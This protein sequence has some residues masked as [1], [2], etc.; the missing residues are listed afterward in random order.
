[1]PQEI[2]TLSSKKR[3]RYGYYYV[4]YFRWINLASVLFVF[5]A[6][7][8]FLL[9]PQYEKARAESDTA[10]I[11]EELASLEEKLARLGKVKSTFDG[12]TLEDQEKID[13]MLPKQEN[14]ENIFPLIETLV[15]RNGLLLVS[16]KAEAVEE[17]VFA[18]KAEQL[19]EESGE[20]QGT[21]GSITAQKEEK[22]PPEIQVVKISLEITGVEYSG[23]KNLLKSLENN[24][25]LMDITKLSFTEGEKCQ[26]EI[27]T[28]YLKSS[29]TKS[30]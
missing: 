5:L 28:Y 20:A 7:G 15:K 4:R 11:N 30:E 6:G 17:K 22:L 27:N 25:R 13:R 23:L 21:G 10:S 26:L 14:L 2:T 3:G 18:T 19:V 9:K 12:I 16:M 24:L 8:F 29:G 1:M